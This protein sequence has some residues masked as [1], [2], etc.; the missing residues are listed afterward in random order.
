MAKRYRLSVFCLLIGIAM[1]ATIAWAGRVLSERET[2]ALFRGPRIL[3]E[4]DRVAYY[5]LCQYRL[6]GSQHEPTSDLD[7]ITGPSVSIRL[8]SRTTHRERRASRGLHVIYPPQDARFPPN[9]CAPFVEWEDGV[10]DRWLMT[11]WIEGLN[12]E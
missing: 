4:P 9:L 12:K 6:A 1:L 7:A 5:P 3:C 11:V 8:Q 2:R 10:N